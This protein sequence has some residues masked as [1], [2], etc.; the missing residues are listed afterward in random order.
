MILLKPLYIRM[1]FLCA[2][3]DSALLLLRIGIA[4][5]LLKS[6]IVT[7]RR[8]F[9]KTLVISTMRYAMLKIEKDFMVV[10]CKRK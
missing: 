4:D 9:R 6:K 5:M 7:L 3:H 10:Q 8:I 2:F 1:K